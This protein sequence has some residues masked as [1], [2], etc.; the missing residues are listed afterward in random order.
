MANLLSISRSSRQPLQ[1]CDVEEDI[2][3]NTFYKPVTNL[4]QYIDKPKKSYV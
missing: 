2:Q 1:R 4:T 3:K